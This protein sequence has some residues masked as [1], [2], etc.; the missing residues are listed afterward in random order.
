M[1]TSLDALEA[2]LQFREGRPA[3]R[4]RARPAAY[5]PLPV[6]NPLDPTVPHLI[7]GD[8]APARRSRS[9]LAP[10]PAAGPVATPVATVVLNPLSARSAKKRPA[11]PVAPPP[12]TVSHGFGVQSP[13][14]SVNSRRPLEVEVRTD[15][16][17]DA[18]Q[19]KP[20]RGKKRE[21]L[22]DLERLELTR[23][24]NREHARCTRMK[25]KARLDHLI[26]TEKR[27]ALLQA[28]EASDD[29][30]RKN[31][32]DLV[33]SAA[34]GECP[35]SSRLHQLA[36]QVVQRPEFSLAGRVALAEDCGMV[37]VSVRG[38]GFESGELKILSGVVCAE[39]GP[40]TAD[41]SSISICWSSPERTGQDAQRAGIPPS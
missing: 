34:E 37:Q 9:S 2:L 32:E 29:L 40:R 8:C 36:S 39:F 15:K 31:L 41:A 30:R 24:R 4:P 11:H 18:L 20:Q 7:E 1:A 13:A 22:S 12:A 38:H 21:N 35:Q 28:K 33:E 10:L 23:T 19:S 26:A 16:I 14:A 25:K 17:K 6:P 5:V 3:K 27:Y